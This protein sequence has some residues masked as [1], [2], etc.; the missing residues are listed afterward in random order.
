MIDRN[1]VRINGWKDG[2]KSYVDLEVGNRVVHFVDYSL[3]VPNVP[4]LSRIPEIGLLM[5]LDGVS[6]CSYWDYENGQRVT[7]KMK[8]ICVKRG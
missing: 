6:S 2:R 5:G 3:S 8:L 4:H 7:E 1:I